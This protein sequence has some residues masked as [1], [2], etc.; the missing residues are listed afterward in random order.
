MGTGPRVYITRRVPEL[1]RGE[2][3]QSFDVDVH[4]DELPP[5]RDALVAGVAGCDGLVT[6]LT[7]RVDA[8]LLD[9][10]GPRL[11]IVANYAVGLD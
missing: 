2:L 8:D 9:A 4:D 11:R 5:S 1:V 6:M 10:A 7:D 3:E